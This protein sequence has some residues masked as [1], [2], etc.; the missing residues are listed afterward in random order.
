MP[1]RSIIAR[2]ALPVCS[3]QR[4]DKI[5]A[6]PVCLATGARTRKTAAPRVVRAA[7][8]ENTKRTRRAPRAN[9]APPG[10]TLKKTT[11]LALCVPPENTSTKMPKPVQPVRFVHGGAS[12][13]LP[14]RAVRFVP[15]AN[16]K[17]G[18]ICLVRSANSARLETN[19]RL[20]TNCAPRAPT[21]ATRARTRPPPLSANFALPAASM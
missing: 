10:R 11:L 12:L 14:S 5:Q 2:P 16:T 9:F 8:W 1:R 19:S 7:K 4:P 6:T 17:S 3:R 18:T 15:Q 21:A 13:Q 20:E